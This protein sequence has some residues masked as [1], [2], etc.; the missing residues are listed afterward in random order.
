MR[1]EENKTNK[2]ETGHR[3]H[4]TENSRGEL[5][6]HL[7]RSTRI[8]K[9]AV[10]AVPSHQ[11]IDAVYNFVDS[12]PFGKRDDVGIS[13]Y[14]TP[15][16]LY[17]TKFNVKFEYKKIGAPWEYSASLPTEE[18]KRI[19][20]D[21]KWIE[22]EKT[23]SS[24]VFPENGSHPI[25]VQIMLSKA[26]CNAPIVAELERERASVFFFNPGSNDFQDFFHTMVKKDD[27]WEAVFEQRPPDQHYPTI[28]RR[29]RTSYI[30]ESDLTVDL[31]KTGYSRNDYEIETEQCGSRSSLSHGVVLLSSEVSYKRLSGYFPILFEYLNKSEWK[32][33]GKCVGAGLAPAFS[34]NRLAYSIEN[35]SGPVLVRLGEPHPDILR[36]WNEQMGG[37]TQSIKKRILIDQAQTILRR[38]EPGS[39]IYFVGGARTVV[40]LKEIP[41]LSDNNVISAN[42]LPLPKMGLNM[43]TEIV[44]KVIGDK[45][46]IASNLT[47]STHAFDRFINRHDIEGVHLQELVVNL[48]VAITNS[49]KNGESELSPQPAFK[50]GPTLV[51]GIEI[52]NK[53]STYSRLVKL[54]EIVIN[55]YAADPATQSE[56]YERYQAE[57]KGLV[58]R[59]KK[60][61]ERAAKKK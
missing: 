37:G 15:Y 50:F 61:K 7:D 48:L 25:Q 10:I 18:V 14:I 3:I 16:Y 30:V 56:L 31:I 19:K 4:Q 41:E 45:V 55:K 33:K 34:F 9:R 49:I 8:F 11:M 28:L 58:Y 59:D 24:S 21:P 53:K 26:L 17:Q 52:T 5:T 39:T 44:A 35:M 23:L 29:L 20:N 32:G 43:D 46:G 40:W 47:K 2:I 13:R 42:K 54:C 27:K 6:R 36:N 60:S 51:Q 12:S 1:G 22:L 57:M 38:M